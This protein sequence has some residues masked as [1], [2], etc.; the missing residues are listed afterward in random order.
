MNVKIVSKCVILLFVLSV[1]SS[2]AAVVVGGAAGVTYTYIKGWLVH[3]YDAN[4]K[5][6]YRAAVKA[7]KYHDLEIYDKGKDL[8][9]AYIKA[10]GADREII[11]RLKRKGKFLTKVSIRVGVMGDRKAGEMI[12]NSIRGYM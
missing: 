12:H 10:R 1:F 4:L 6:T 7:V 11:V 3:D 8:T 5:V 2:C 9:V